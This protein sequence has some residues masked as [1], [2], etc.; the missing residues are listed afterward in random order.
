MPLLYDSCVFSVRRLIVLVLLDWGWGRLHRAERLTQKEAVAALSRDQVLVRDHR[1]WNLGD[2]CPGHRPTWPHW[3]VEALGVDF[4]GHVVGADFAWRN[5]TST[6]NKRELTKEE[7]ELWIKRL[8]MF[9]RL[10]R[11]SLSGTAVTDTSL[12]HL[13]GL[14][15]LRFLRV[16]DT[17]VSDAG[18]VEL[19]H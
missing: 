15:G 14:T 13:I 11:L 7:I 5:A 12:P 16:D 18:L 1:Q 9:D 6:G 17:P 19:G 2:C 4:F 10:E 8:T 3:M